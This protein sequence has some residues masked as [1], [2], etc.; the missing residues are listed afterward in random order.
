MSEMEFNL[1][2]NF[3]LDEFSQSIAI[4]LLAMYPE[5]LGHID[6]NQVGFVRKQC[7]LSKAAKPKI[8]T[9]TAVRQPIRGFSSVAWLITTMG[10]NFTHLPLPIKQRVIYHGLTHIPEEEGGVVPHDVEDFADCINKWG[11]NW[12]GNYD[13]EPLFEMEDE[14]PVEEMPDEI[15]DMKMED[16]KHQ[17]AKLGL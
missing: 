6:L 4:E 1:G 12:Q 17:I 5:E 14:A 10:E 11:T 8:A 2:D 7:G 16:L 9:C 3:S 13:L 15:K